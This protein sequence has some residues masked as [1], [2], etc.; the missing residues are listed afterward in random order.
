[1]KPIAASDK[2]AFYFMLGARFFKRYVRNVAIQVVQ[3]NIIGLMYHFAT[4]RISGV[5]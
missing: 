2:L 1:M 5:V 3:L 4:H